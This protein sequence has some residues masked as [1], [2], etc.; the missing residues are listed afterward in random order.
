MKK[1]DNT[2]QAIL[3]AAEKEFLDKLCVGQNNRYCAGR[4]RDAC[5]ATLLLPDERET[6]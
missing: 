3:Q 4:R 6:V 5:H 2:E 1:E